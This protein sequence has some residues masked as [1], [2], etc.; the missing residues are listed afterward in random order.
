MTHPVPAVTPSIAA[1][2]SPEENVAALSNRILLQSYAPASVT[3]DIN[4]NI[5]YVHGDISR[6][7]RQP[8]GV[9]T[10]NVVEMAREGLQLALRSA[11]LAAAQGTPTLGQEVSLKTET[12]KFKV[13]CSLRVMP[14]VNPDADSLLLVSFKEIAEVA[15]PARRSGGFHSP[16]SY[17]MDKPLPGANG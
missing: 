5:L 14:P 10:T 6:F 1:R 2:K 3:T 11:L 17:R 9:V 13:S 7:L 4:G 16:V 12:G 15:K 8:A